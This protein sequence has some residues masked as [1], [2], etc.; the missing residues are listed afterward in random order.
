MQMFDNTRK[1]LIVNSRGER[2]IDYRSTLSP[3]FGLVWLHIGLGYAALAAILVCLVYLQQQYMSWWWLSVPAGGFMVGYA[4]AYI[5]LFTHEAS[6]YNIAAGKETNDLLANLFL[7]SLVGMDIRFYRS[8][9]LLHH[10]YLGTT[11]DTEKS[12][13]EPVS[14]RFIIESLTGIRVWKVMTHRNKNVQLNDDGSAADVIARNK[15][16]FLASAFLNVAFVVA[17]LLAGYWQAALAWL[18]GMGSVFPF[19][20]SVRQILEHRQE[21]AD[22]AVDYNT[23]DHGASHRMFGDGLLAI[24][25]GPAGFNRHLLHHWDPQVSY[26]RLREVE[27]FLS[28]TPLGR[29]IEKSRTTYLKTFASLF[30]F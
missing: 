19:L 29:S 18:I 10:Q 22:S 13:F 7:G 27:D 9:H 15:R 16:M 23:V 8:M 20:A 17:F 12:Y 11:R 28:D 5:H 3:R 25:L 24:T 1:D 4:V 26:T 14:T 2:Y 30:R 6:H 21:A